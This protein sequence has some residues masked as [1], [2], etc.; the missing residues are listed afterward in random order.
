M[1]NKKKVIASVVLASAVTLS[2][3]G[4]ELANGVQV[5][6]A[7][8]A[9]QAVVDTKYVKYGHVEVLGLKS[10]QSFISLRYNTFYKWNHFG[11]YRN[12]SFEFTLDPKLAP[13]VTEV[14]GPKG[15][16]AMVNEATHSFSFPADKLVRFA[17]IGVPQEFTVDVHLNQPVGALPVDNYRISARQLLAN[18]D[19]VARTQSNAYMH[20]TNEVT[21]VYQSKLIR[22]ASLFVNAQ[23]V[24]TR[25]DT[26]YE[27]V[28]LLNALSLK[29]SKVNLS[30]EP[31]LLGYLE[32]IEVSKDG[33]NW[34]TITYN[35]QGKASY[36]ANELL[37]YSYIGL[38]QDFFVR[39]NLKNQV[40][41]LPDHLYT[42]NINIQHP[43]G[44][45][46]TKSNTTGYFL[47]EGN[48][49]ET[50]E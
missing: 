22:Q 13:Y 10:E 41:A 7:A 28:F 48:N 31:T 5:G 4:I 8:Q 30:F 9:A 1:K 16:K 42:F 29:D 24:N 20:V 32:S 49:V 18:G 17:L 44:G 40:Q 33:R 39:Y 12:G 50:R 47:V 45:I 14:T 19:I 46:V 37:S 15:L 27:L 3:T 23:P 6:N 36:P 43:N 11:T 38:P 34:T 26:K 21:N 35:E 2:T 25:V